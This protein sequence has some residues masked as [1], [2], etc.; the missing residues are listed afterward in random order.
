MR[1]DAA[2]A[3]KALTALR[4]QEI[5]R[6]KARLQPYNLKEEQMAELPAWVL[7][8]QRSHERRE[9]ISKQLTA[10]NFPFK[11]VVALDGHEELDELEVSG[12]HA[13]Y[14]GPLSRS[15]LASEC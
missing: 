10:L 4:W 2:L 7:S 13:G 12:T 6:A 1:F 14:A 9:S 5:E 11:I 8:M 15:D 3:N